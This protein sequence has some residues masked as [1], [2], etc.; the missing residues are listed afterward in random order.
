MKSIDLILNMCF[1]KIS[2][3]QVLN[4]SVHYNHIPRPVFDALAMEELPL[5][6][7]TET[8]KIYQH[9]ETGEKGINVFQLLKCVAGELLLIREDKPVC[10]YSQILR[11]RSVVRALG[12]D[13]PIC[14]FLADRAEKSR[15][16]WADFEWSPVIGHD[17]MQMNRIMQKG[18]ADNHFHLFGSA[19]SFQ[20]SWL[21][22]MNDLNNP[23]IIMQLREMDQ[24]RRV[25]RPHYAITYQE[26]SMEEMYFQAGVLRAALFQY[27]QEAQ[28][29]D[30]SE[31]DSVIKSY[32]L[33]QKILT[34]KVYKAVYF[35][36]IQLIIKAM[37]DKAI[38]QNPENT[39]D[40]A[41]N[42]FGKEGNNHDFEGERA[43]LYY[44][45]L[46]RI[47]CRKIPD[48]IQDWLY[49]YLLIKGKFYEELVQVNEKVGFANF[50]QYSGRKKG[51]LYT[52][53]DDRRMVQHAVAGSMESKNMVSLEVRVT[54]CIKS[55]DNKKMISAFDNYIK[56]RIE[57]KELKRIYY[58]FH[59]PKSQ[60][61][62]ALQNDRYV[63]RCR[64]YGYRQKLLRSAN[65]LIQFREKYPVEAE[66]V[67]GIDACAQ[68]IGCRPEVFGPAFR[69]MT[70][71][72]CAPSVLYHVKQWKISYHVGEDWLDM[73]DGLRAIDEAIIFLG[74]RNGDRLGHATVL[75]QNVRKWYQ[76]KGHEI[77]LPLQDYL[78]NVVWLYHKLIEF[79]IHSCEALKGFLRGEYEKYFWQLYG[80]FLD[81]AI[82][83]DIA[84]K[85]RE[86]VDYL[87]FDIDTYY[88]AWKLRGDDPSLYLNGYYCDPYYYLQEYMVNNNIPNGEQ[89]RSCVKKG[90]LIYYYHYCTEVRRE[91]MKPHHIAVPDGYI[92][93]VRKVQKAM[94]WKI[95]GLGIGIESN[96]SSNYL[97][98]TMEKYEDHPIT[99]FYNMGLSMEMEEIRNCPQLH[100]SINTDD[101]GVFHTSLENEFALMGC[102]IEQQVDGNGKYKYAKQMV[103]EWI[104]HIRE[105]GIQQSFLERLPK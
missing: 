55:A 58:V 53:E 19:P 62:V 9:L 96:P 8:Q 103:Y 39:I 99:N 18:I 88:D 76:C 45:L 20:L 26:Y 46:G 37:R 43:L 30:Y 28:E 50:S 92:D 36:K 75:G 70:G 23:A 29:L 57:E 1:Q 87:C 47:N 21:K 66:R 5:L 10:C 69:C 102:A 25:I 31:A 90:I 16:S 42:G 12:E 51:F 22:M 34:D 41:L 78:D 77:I 73:V 104:E 35:Q 27:T 89:L 105:N 59:F 68:E 3:E 61:E 79:D 64:H 2:V 93:G 95:A 44:L 40:Y 74:M 13:L 81:K 97:I 52:K 71:H 83:E 56:E 4:G 32:Q 38:L 11:W 94:Q 63:N 49:A 54:P 101:R 85:Q 72:V 98:S 33:I 6:S 60:D 65:E 48:V 7:E 67:L 24:K 15:D 100:V 84:Q 86:N 17:N 82:I 91:G 80:Q 14:A